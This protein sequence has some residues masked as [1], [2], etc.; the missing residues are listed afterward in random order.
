MSSVRLATPGKTRT[1]PHCRTEILASAAVCPSCRH[2][3]RFGG[4]SGA[5][6]SPGVAA[7]SV[8]GTIHHPGPRPLEYTVV[9]TLKNEQGQEV[10]RK[11]VSVGALAQGEARTFNVSVEVHEP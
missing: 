6:A 10:L 8:D 7:L 1:C 9:V 3:L 4:A 2:H 11:V 5:E